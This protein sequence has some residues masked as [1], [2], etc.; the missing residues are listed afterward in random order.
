MIDVALDCVGEEPEKR[1]LK[2]CS[3]LS[4]S[5]SLS[6]YCDVITRPTGNGERGVVK[7]RQVEEGSA[8]KIRSKEKKLKRAEQNVD[9]WTQG[10]IQEQIGENFETLRH[11]N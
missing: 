6:S 9:N 5:R 1:P 8:K 11:V 10:S 7:E 4:I 3:P 2:I